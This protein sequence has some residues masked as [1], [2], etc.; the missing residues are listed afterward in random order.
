MFSLPSSKLFIKTVNVLFQLEE[1]IWAIHNGEARIFSLVAWSIVQ[2]EVQYSRSFWL[3]RDYMS[4][5]AP[6]I[7]TRKITQT[8]T[9]LTSANTS[10]VRSLN[11]YWYIL[12]KSGIIILPFKSSL[13]QW[14]RITNSE[15][16]CSSN[17]ARLGTEAHGSL[18][19]ISFTEQVEMGNLPKTLAASWRTVLEETRS[20]PQ[21]LWMLL[22]YSD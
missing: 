9:V 18:M 20:N 15:S 8:K 16:I 21:A 10:R 19:L 17:C 11:S 14:Q 13:R 6:K 3:V 22:S 5:K 12:V 1:V 2:N 7:I 4:L